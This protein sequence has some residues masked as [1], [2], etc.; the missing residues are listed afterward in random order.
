MCVICRHYEYNP[1]VP[2]IALCVFVFQGSPPGS[3][4]KGNNPPGPM[5]PPHRLSDSVTRPAQRSELASP[6]QPL[7]PPPP[8]ALLVSLV[9]YAPNNVFTKNVLLLFSFCLVS[10]FVYL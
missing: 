2:T 3:R 7:P 8:L 9:R 10:S 1:H 5:K 6:P 4:G